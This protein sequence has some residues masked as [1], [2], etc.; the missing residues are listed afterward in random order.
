ML[1]AGG[2]AEGRAAAA[3]AVPPPPTVVE[4]WGVWEAAWRYDIAP[5]RDGNT[6]AANPFT[7]VSLFVDFTTTAASRT[8]AVNA[9][10]GFYDG[11]GTYRARFMPRASGGYAWR[12]RSNILALHNRTGRFD[13]VDAQRPQNRGPVV[14][15]PGPN[16]TTFEYADGTPFLLAG[17]TVYGLFGGWGSGSDPNSSTTARTLQ[18]LR[19][20]PF[21]KV[22][23]MAFPVGNPAA[24]PDLLP[25]VP[26]ANTTATTNG[27]TAISNTTVLDLTR[28]NPPF[29]RHLDG[30]PV[31]GFNP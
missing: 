12:T 19:S 6:G 14:V 2:R 29:W 31:C 20:T 26:L 11:G 13:V 10:R 1:L 15:A 3:A 23:S 25:Y 24:H 7:D 28:F 8:V 18:T 4:R 22:R 5:P 9:V 30:V 21:N 16:A 27:S 17:T